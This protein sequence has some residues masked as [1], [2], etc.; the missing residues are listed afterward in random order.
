M[1]IAKLQSKISFRFGAVR[2]VETQAGIHRIYC[3]IYVIYFIRTHITIIILIWI[4]V[5]DSYVEVP[6]FKTI[7]A[8]II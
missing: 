6:I 3:M 2:C 5:G 7:T 8:P 4:T 1:D